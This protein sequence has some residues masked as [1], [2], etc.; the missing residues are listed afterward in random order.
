MR[1]NKDSDLRWHSSMSKSIVDPSTDPAAMPFFPL[2]SLRDLVM[3]N[4]LNFAMQY[5][6]LACGAVK[7][8]PLRRTR[9][10]TVRQVHMTV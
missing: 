7:H 8:P 3:Q 10:K 2:Q 1:K 9:V 4:F 5:V 6:S